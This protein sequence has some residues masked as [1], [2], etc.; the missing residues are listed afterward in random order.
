MHSFLDPG[1]YE[2]FT[3]ILAME[4]QHVQSAQV[5]ATVDEVRILNAIDSLAPMFNA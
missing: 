5:W 3:T 1:V 2:L 4:P